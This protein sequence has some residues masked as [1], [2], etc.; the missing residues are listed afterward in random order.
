MRVLFVGGIGIISTAVSRLAVA[1]G[2]DLWLCN[3]GEHPIALAGARHVRANVND[4][5]A[6]RTALDAV[7]MAE[8]PDRGLE[9][10][11]RCG[12][13]AAFGASAITHPIVW[14]V[15]FDPSWTA[16]HW[17][18]VVAAELFAW[19]AEAAYFRFLF[20]R[21]RAWLWSL[22]AN[23]ASFG[24]GLLSRWIFGAP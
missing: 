16:G 21:P 19:A 13:L 14:F 2:V 5:A 7:L 17:T 15:F 6:V 11:V 4:A 22:I 20:R 3:R 10:L 1:R 24:A 9:V 18:K 8:R 12:V 23:G